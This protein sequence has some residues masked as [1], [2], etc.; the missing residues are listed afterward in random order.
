MKITGK[1]ERILW[2][3]ALTVLAAFAMKLALEPLLAKAAGLRRSIRAYE[4]ELRE[5]R[6]L[7]S[8]ENRIKDFYSRLPAS[9]KLDTPAQDHLSATLSLLED[10][11][12]QAGLRV[13]DVRPA[14]SYAGK[15]KSPAV[16]IRQEGDMAA[17]MKFI[18][19]VESSSANLLI[20]RLN[21][22]ARSGGGDLAIEALVSGC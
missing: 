4:A 15:S 1:R 3:A 7:I 5:Y 16:N 22:T 20:R 19:G 9:A 21:I 2:A 10:I 13:I 6:R 14:E 18:A 17:V 12:R 11:S 8:Q